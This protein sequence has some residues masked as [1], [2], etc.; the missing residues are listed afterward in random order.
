MS[1]DDGRTRPRHE[2]IPQR[3]T[4]NGRYREDEFNGGS[5]WLRYEHSQVYD[6]NVD[7]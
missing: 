2:P 3:S 4:T 1:R 7:E 5:T 6:P